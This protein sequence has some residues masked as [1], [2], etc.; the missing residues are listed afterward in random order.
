MFG[1]Y[2]IVLIAISYFVPR[3]TFTF[4]Q[5]QSNFKS[6][7]AELPRLRT[8]HPSNLPF[9]NIK[10]VSDIMQRLQYNLITLK[11]AGEQKIRYFDLCSL[12]KQLFARSVFC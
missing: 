1:C 3:K 4:L 8:P 6:E 12:R 9:L 5:F 11:K 2:L 10:P 7:Y